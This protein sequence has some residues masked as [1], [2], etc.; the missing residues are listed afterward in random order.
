METIKRKIA[1]LKA[2]LDAKDEEIATLRAELGHE[3]IEREKA[4]NEAS[5]HLRKVINFTVLKCHFSII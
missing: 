1:T 5:G 2:D 4:E 3:K